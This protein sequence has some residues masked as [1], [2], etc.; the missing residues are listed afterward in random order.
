MED[1]KL[2]LGCGNNKIDGY[3]NVDLY[4]SPDFKFDLETFPWPWE[5]SSVSEIILA[6]VLEHLGQTPNV[7]LNIIKELYRV[8]K[9]EALI[10]IIVPHPRHDDFISDPT[11]VRAITPLGLSLFSKKDNVRWQELGVSN[12]PFALYIEVDFEIIAIRNV[13]D[14]VWE[15]KMQEEEL[16]SEDIM[17]ASQ[18]F[19]NVIKQIEIDWRVIK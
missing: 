3:V 11:H 10:K 18:S 4:G 8:C 16:K 17:Y 12:T 1:L 2:N 9:N 5:T 19:N 15:K 7:Y 13:L 14:P 6:H